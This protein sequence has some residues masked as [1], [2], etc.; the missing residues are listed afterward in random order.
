MGGFGLRDL[1]RAFA[2]LDARLVLVARVRFFAEDFPFFLGMTLCVEFIDLL[3]TSFHLSYLLLPS[4]D[5]SCRLSCHPS[6]RL[7]S[8]MH[9]SLSCHDPIRFSFRHR[10][11]Y[12]RSPKRDSSLLSWKRPHPCNLR[13]C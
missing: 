5:P 3:A 4:A 7:S 9:D 10:I 6:S 8:T 2:P 1:L 13:R 11:L 12:L